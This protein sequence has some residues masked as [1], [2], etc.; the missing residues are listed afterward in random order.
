M[1]FGT[2]DLGLQK[3]AGEL[4]RQEIEYAFTGWSGA[5]LRAPYG[6][7]EMLMAYVDRMPTESSALFPSSGDGNVV[8]YLPQDDGALLFKRKSRGG[9]D[10]V[11]DLQLY[12]DLARMPGRAIEQSQVL[13]DKHL[14]NGAQ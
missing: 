12:V 10:V 2:Y 6:T 14:K 7:S 9:F 8:L 11:S 4:R 3:L 5:F 13:R 1:S